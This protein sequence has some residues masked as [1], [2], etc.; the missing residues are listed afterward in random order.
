MKL[1][2]VSNGLPFKINPKTQK[3]EKNSGGLV[4]TLTSVHTKDEIT[5]VGIG[6]S[7]M[8]NCHNDEQY[9]YHPI[10]V[11]TKKYD[12]YYN[13]FCNE[14][15]WPL[16]HYSL[17]SINYTEEAWQAY[18][19]VNQTFAENILPLLND[20]DIVWV[21]D[22]HLFLLPKLIK[23]Q[24]PNVKVG[25]FL[26]IPFPAY[27]VFSCLPHNKNILD[28]VMAADLIG[29]NDSKYKDLFAQSADAISNSKT[30]N[31][32]IKLE[33]HKLKLIACPVGIDSPKFSKP[34]KNLENLDILDLITTEK[35]I[36]G[37]E[38]LDPIKG[39]DLKLKAFDYFLENYPE[40]QGKVSLIQ[41][42]IPTRTKVQAYQQL[43]S[44]I[45][46][47]IAEINLKFG[48]QDYK[49]I[50]YLYISVAFNDM[51]ELYRHTDVIWITSKRD[52]FN[53]IGE[54]YVASQNSDN[55]GVLLLSKF[56]GL[57]SVLPE[58]L[59]FNP[60]DV[61]ESATELKRALNLD[62][63]TR[64]KLYKHAHEYVINHS[65]TDWAETFVE[66]L[67]NVR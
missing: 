17:D 21:H 26:H 41:I 42:A 6:E 28:G 45:E 25:F 67:I 61:V 36:L 47:Q 50:N 5:W 19:E 29:F 1:F 40:Y 9:S 16:F 30:N 55:P 66:N 58:C 4:S 8:H 46:K 65:A 64:S 23:Q 27:E 48:T 13:K 37:V 34:S 18:V 14:A 15:L 38:R 20:D 57:A 63:P 39:L 10:Q 2:V 49:P 32:E 54:E 7:E 52:G 44:D 12:L 24:K 60:W 33:A 11:D 62:K 51:C 3:I 22:F 43:K 35:T 31:D 53:L 59:K 56:A